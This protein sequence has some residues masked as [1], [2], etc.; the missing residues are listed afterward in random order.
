MGRVEGKLARALPIQGQVEEL[1]VVNL[2]RFFA[3]AS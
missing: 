2:R 3:R 1:V